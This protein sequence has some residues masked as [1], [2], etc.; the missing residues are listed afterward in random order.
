LASHGK[1]AGEAALGLC[2][3][4][5]RGE[6]RLSYAEEEIPG[7]GKLLLLTYKCENCGYKTNDLMPLEA[8]EPSSYKVRIEEV[9][10]L[11]V[12][13]VKASSGFVEIPE[14]GVEIKPGPA[15]EGYV[16]NVEGLLAR[17]EEAAST[18][19]GDR[20]V[21]GNLKVF[22]ETLRKAI[23]GVKV[24]TVIVRDPLGSSALVSE[25]PGKVERTP[26]SREEAERLRRQLVGVA[27][28][29]K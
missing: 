29:Y 3:F 16:T 13:V 8:R 7:F 23:N 6:L 14:L 18:L 26:L 10:D 1:P 25:V 2:P 22:L 27:L 5:R 21:E 15:S 9:K 20:E 28:E 17:I 11:N 19:K 4:C 12:K 24:F